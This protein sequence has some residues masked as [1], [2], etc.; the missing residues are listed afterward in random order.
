MLLQSLCFKTKVL[1]MVSRC[2]CYGG[3]KQPE[4]QNLCFKDKGWS[5]VSK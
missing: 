5:I 4:L 2:D 3:A 1:S